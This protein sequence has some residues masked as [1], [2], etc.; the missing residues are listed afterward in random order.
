MI[1]RTRTEINKCIIHKVANK[2]N[3]GQNAF[4]ESLV[5]F[6]EESYELLLPFLLKPFGSVTQSYRF[7]HRG[8]LVAMNDTIFD[9]R[10]VTKTNTTSVSTFQSPNF[11]PIGYIHNSDAKYSIGPCLMS[12]DANTARQEAIPMPLSAPRVVPFAVTH[13]PSMYG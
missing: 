12:V 6:D 10:D 2:Y 3:S 7:S 9:A 4:S 11:G 13:S 1:K 8:V 5:R